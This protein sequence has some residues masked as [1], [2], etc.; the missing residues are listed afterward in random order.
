[1]IQH[2]PAADRAVDESETLIRGLSPLQ[3][4]APFAIWALDLA[5][6]QDPGTFAWLSR[7]ERD[8]IAAFRFRADGERRA[9]AHVALRWLLA[10]ESGTAPAALRFHEGARGR[11]I[12]TNAPE[13]QFSLSYS[14]GLAI[15]GISRGYAHIGIDIEA[16]RDIPEAEELAAL[17]F[18]QSEWQALVRG[19]SQ[20]EISHLF[21]EGWARKEACLK[22]LSEGL[23]IDPSEIQSGLGSSHV[24]IRQGSR[25][26]IEVESASDKH[27][28]I[29]WARMR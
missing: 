22:A 4:G 18:Q 6:P 3:L 1:M 24:V 12:A 13:L 10:R 21:L 26:A 20:A 5:V 9:A 16:L 25:S 17:Y 19:R 29:A 11:P 8:R 28:I 2:L 7:E 14:K 15:I 27:H 23:Y